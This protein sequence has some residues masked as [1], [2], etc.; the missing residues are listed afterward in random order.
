M[1]NF[2]REN[3]KI[4]NLLILQGRALSHCLVTKEIRHVIHL[5]TFFKNTLKYFLAGFRILVLLNLELLPVHSD[6]NKL[7]L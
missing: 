2:A 5:N 6:I 3:L 7:I 4:G 1:G